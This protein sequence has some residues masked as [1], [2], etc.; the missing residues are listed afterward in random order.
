MADGLSHGPMAEFTVPDSLDGARLDKA[1]FQLATN[2]SRAQMKRAIADGL[3]RVNGRARPKG[4]LVAKGEV[5]AIDLARVKTINA[6]AEA[7]PDADLVVRLENDAVLVVDKPAGQPTA[8]LRPGETGTIAN[9]V[10]GRYPEVA[11]IGYFAREPGLVHRLDT[12]TSGL[13]IVARTRDA[14][15]ILKTAL[16]ANRI[17]KSYQLVCSEAGLP[18]QGTIEF[19][20]ANHPK[21]Q[22]RVYPCVHPRDVMRY[23]PRPAK[24][25]YRVLERAARWALVEA[26]VSRALRHQ[27]RAHFAAI[28]HPL[29]GDR[30]YG[31]AEIRALGRH[32]L[33]ASRVVFAG[34]AAVPA[35]DV[36]SPLPEEMAA[37]LK[38]SA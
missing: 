19:G 8:P 28:E 5:I 3:V 12:D 23:Q 17:E 25:E 18:D 9:A 24:T 33:H 4:A 29:A 31:G 2:V 11:E 6:P 22:R 21:D 1:L 35:F 30:L 34:E 38:E 10:V 16:R 27:I 37:L 13:I 15:E 7:T 36:S 20:I 32:A 26:H 14:F